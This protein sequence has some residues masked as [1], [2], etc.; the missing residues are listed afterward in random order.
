MKETGR[1]NCE[2]EKEQIGERGRKIWVER[3]KDW[4]REEEGIG[5]K[6]KNKLGEERKK[7]MGRRGRNPSKERKKNW[8]GE[9]EK[10]GERRKKK[11]GEKKKNWWR[12]EEPGEEEK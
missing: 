4:G 2:R 6:R 5:R 1:K 3:K 8:E 11:N 7:K 10:L 12:V 9:K